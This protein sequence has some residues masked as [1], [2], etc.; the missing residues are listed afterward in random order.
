MSAVDR[1]AL[2]MAE[3]G[4][5]P[6]LKAAFELQGLPPSDVRLGVQRIQNRISKKSIAVAEIV[7]T[8]RNRISAASQELLASKVE[9]AQQAL[10]K[11]RELMEEEGTSPEFR[12]SVAK[13]LLDRTL[14]A[15]K[16]TRQEIASHHTG[17]LMLPDAKANSL[18]GAMARAAVAMER[19][20][21]EIQWQEKPIPDDH[22][23]PSPSETELTPIR[24]EDPDEI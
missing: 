21:E 1:I 12:A 15:S 22:R 24:I 11:L 4:A 23:L 3:S 2:E 13:D 6:S 8:I 5:V 7:D 9:A 16:V 18:L 20:P 10:A 19:R 17:S 14:E